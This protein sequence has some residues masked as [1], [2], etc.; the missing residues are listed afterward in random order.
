MNTPTTQKQVQTAARERVGLKRYLRACGVTFIPEA[1]T[2]ALWDLACRTGKSLDNPWQAATHS[3]D[4][5]LN[6][7]TPAT[8][9]AFNEFMA[10]QKPLKLGPTTYGYQRVCSYQNLVKGRKVWACMVEFW[11]GCSYDYIAAYLS[12]DREEF[13]KTWSNYPDETQTTE[14]AEAEMSRRHERGG[15]EAMN[16]RDDYYSALDRDARFE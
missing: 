4:Y 16:A 15:P 12:G 8:A 9:T 1:P 13:M 7:W 11:D 2:S 14:E 10:G 6:L 3:I 5:Q